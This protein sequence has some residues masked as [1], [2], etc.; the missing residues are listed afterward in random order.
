MSNLPIKSGLL[1]GNARA[2]FHLPVWAQPFLLWPVFDSTVHRSC[3]YPMS[4]QPSIPHSSE[5]LNRCD[6][7]GHDSTCHVNG[8]PLELIHHICGLFF[9]GHTTSIPCSSPEIF[10]ASSRNASNTATLAT[11]PPLMRCDPCCRSRIPPSTRCEF[12][13]SLLP[14][15]VENRVLFALEP[16]IAKVFSQLPACC[17]CVLSLWR[18]L[19]TKTD[20]APSYGY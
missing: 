18:Y 13:K 1:R 17:I 19:S 12:V 3:F 5:N 10:L 9:S 14:G 7:H 16:L 6:N 15:F 8:P 20:I 2:R 11:S 4:L